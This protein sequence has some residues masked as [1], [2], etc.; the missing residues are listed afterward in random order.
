[1]IESFPGLDT[2]R[3]GFS[4]VACLKIDFAPDHRL[5]L[6]EPGQ[7]LEFRYGAIIRKPALAPAHR[8]LELFKDAHEINCVPTQIRVAVMIH[9]KTHA[10]M[11]PG[12]KV[13]GSFQTPKRTRHSIDMAIS[14]AAITAA[15]MKM[16]D[17]IGSFPDRNFGTCY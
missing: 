6:V 7:M 8:L 15:D 4:L 16:A 10:A 9:M 3:P 12:W 2:A 13:R 5:V 11:F 14:R 1:M 17:M